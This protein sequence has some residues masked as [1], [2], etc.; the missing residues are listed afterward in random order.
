M[1]GLK[2]K[3]SAVKNFV[4]ARNGHWKSG[5]W[6]PDTD[7][8]RFFWKGACSNSPNLHSEETC[9]IFH[10]GQPRQHP[11]EGGSSLSVSAG[12]SLNATEITAARLEEQRMESLQTL[13]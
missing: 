7:S 9:H 5:L 4:P 6:T 3:N 12:L 13:E 2:K 8:E 1:A 11:W 10:S